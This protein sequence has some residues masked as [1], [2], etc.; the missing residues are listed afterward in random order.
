[1]TRINKPEVAMPVVRR[2]G[3]DIE[4]NGEFGLAALS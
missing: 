2:F 4:R 1:M 3:R